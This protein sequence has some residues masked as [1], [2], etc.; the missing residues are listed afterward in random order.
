MKAIVS[1]K[2]G[3]PEVLQIQEVEKPVPKDNEILVKVAAVTVSAADRRIRGFDVP[4]SFR[5]PA[6]LLLGITKLRNPVLGMDFA[7]EVE[8]VGKDVKKYKIGDGVYGLTGRKFGTYAQYI[9]ISGE[10]N[11]AGVSVTPGNLSLEEAAAVP[12]GGMTA[13]YFLREANIQEGQKVLITGAAGSVGSF[14]VQLAKYYGAEVTAVCRNDKIDFVKSLGADKV[15]DYTKEDFTNSGEIYD[16]IF[17]AAGK[18]SFFGCVKS[19]AKKGAL[20]HAVPEPT[21]MIK[22]FWAK[23]T[24][25][26]KMVGGGP[27]LS[28]QDLLFLKEL[29][30]SGK[31]KPVIDRIYPMEQII[32]AHKFVESGNKKGNVVIT[33][34]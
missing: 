3:P 5:L 1:A 4:P 17:D 22:M 13:L 2:Y 28:E 27:P 26:K 14:G 34:E 15:I 7:G 32:E 10:E 30:E 23:L 20:L 11:K 31:L 29:I 9:C 8:A 33:M 21:V 18:A 16:V 25:G 6:R 19:L 24:T 12:F